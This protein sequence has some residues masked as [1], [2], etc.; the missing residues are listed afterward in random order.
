MPELIFDGGVPGLQRRG[1]K[2]IAQRVRA[3]RAERDGEC[4]REGCGNGGGSVHVG[5][6]GCGSYQR[7][8]K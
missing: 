1:L 7:R 3:E 2:V 4:T 6:H 8:S 5:L